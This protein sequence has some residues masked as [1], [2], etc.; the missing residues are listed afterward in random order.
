MRGVVGAGEEVAAA[1][2]EPLHGSLEEGSNRC[3]IA[4][5][6]RGHDVAHRLAIEH[7]VGVHVLR[8]AEPAAAKLK[9]AQCRPF[10]TMREDSEA[11]HLA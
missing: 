2:G 3:M 9:E 10:R 7:D 8:F 6:P 4:R 1:I 5:V 11:R